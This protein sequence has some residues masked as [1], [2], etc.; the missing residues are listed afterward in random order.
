MVSFIPM[1]AVY[2]LM[3]VVSPEVELETDKKQTDFLKKILGEDV[4]VTSITSLGKK[5]LA[6]AIKK[7]TQATYLVAELT[8]AAIKVGDIEKKT[9][10]NDQVLRYLL[11]VKG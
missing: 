4:T 5:Q 11:T 6:Y 10:L 8:A 7:Q 2:E 1:N 3:V 9:R